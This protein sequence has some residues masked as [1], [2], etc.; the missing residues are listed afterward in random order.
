MHKAV[1]RSGG[2]SRL[3]FPSRSLSGWYR[4]TEAERGGRNTFV[5]DLLP[6]Y[7]QILWT[8]PSSRVPLPFWGLIRFKASSHRLNTAC[9]WDRKKRHPAGVIT[10]LAG[11]RWTSFALNFASSSKA[12]RQITSMGWGTLINRKVRKEQFSRWRTHMFWSLRMPSQV[13]PYLSLL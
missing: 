10:Q 2:S 13:F 5:S 3:T 11:T 12:L 6:S 8:G 4:S 9:S 1:R 7:A